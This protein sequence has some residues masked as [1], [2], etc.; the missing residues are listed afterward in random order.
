LSGRGSRRA[1]LLADRCARS[2]LEPHRDR[3]SPEPHFVRKPDSNGAGGRLASD[4]DEIPDATEHRLVAEQPEVGV[5][6]IGAKLFAEPNDPPVAYVYDL[7][8]GTQPA[9]TYLEGAIITA[10]HTIVDVPDDLVPE[11]GGAQ[12]PFTSTLNVDGFDVDSC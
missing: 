6:Q 12:V 11:L 9:N 7:T 8:P 1:L 10:G 5:Y 4:P 2:S 3:I